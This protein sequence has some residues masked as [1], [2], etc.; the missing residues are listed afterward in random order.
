MNRTC[1]LTDD[2]LSIIDSS[3]IILPVHTGTRLD[4]Q[5]IVPFV[6]YPVPV[7]VL[8]FPPLGH[9]HVHDSVIIAYYLFTPCL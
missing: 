3:L 6:C 1:E 8:P 9:S 7:L 4:L 5:R 2:R